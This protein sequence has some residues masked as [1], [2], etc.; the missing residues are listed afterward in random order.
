M[1]TGNIVGK[2]RE[3]RFGRSEVERKIKR[4]AIKWVDKERKGMGAI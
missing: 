2:V 1:K 3:G 4:G